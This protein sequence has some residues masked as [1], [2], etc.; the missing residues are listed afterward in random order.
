MAT[1]PSSIDSFAGFTSTDTLAHDNHAS[2]EN[3]QE[4]AIVAIETK[5]GTGA[6]TSTNNT[7]LRGNGSGTSTFDQVHLATDVSGVLSA[8]NGGSGTS[9]TT[10]SGA[11]VLQTSPTIIT[12]IVSDFTNSSH[13]HQ[14]TAGGGILS[15][16]AL[17]LSN[18]TTNNASASQHGFLPKL[19]GS[20]TQYLDG[21]GAWNAFSGASFTV[22]PTGWA[23]TPT[24]TGTYFQ[25]GKLVI[26]YYN[27]TGTSNSTAASASLPVTAAT[28]A[29]GN[30][31]FPYRSIDNGVAGAGAGQAFIVAGGTTV[32]FFK[33]MSSGNWTS[34][35]TKSIDG[36]ILFYIAA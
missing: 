27:I 5:L 11:L 9:S 14:N 18:N 24:S 32:S 7:V 2:Q 22:S 31:N 3:Q 21:T 4:T 15:E 26:V 36:A 25:L 30:F 20:A 16:T 28:P 10:G 12:P 19:S 34:S 6:S 13:N 1:F 29:S 23:A 17:S 33:D 35:G 8:S